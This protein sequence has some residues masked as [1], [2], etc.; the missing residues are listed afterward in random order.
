MY[1]RLDKLPILFN[2][3]KISVA[4][5]IYNQKLRKIVNVF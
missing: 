2:L 5:Y 1:L 3:Y 4:I